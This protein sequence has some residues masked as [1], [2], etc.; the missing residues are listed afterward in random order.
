MAKWLRDNRLSILIFLIL[1]AGFLVRIFFVDKVVVGDLMSYGEWGQRLIQ[2]G[3]KNL[4]FGEGWYYSVPNYPPVAVWTFAGM[5]WLNEH[6]YVL[7]Q[8]HNV[9]RFP[10]SAFIVYF[11]KWGY[12]LLL[13]LPSIIAD[14]GLSL[15]IYKLIFSLTKST[16]KSIA[17]MVLFLFNPI[18]IFISGAWGQTDSIVA[19]LATISFLFLLKKNFIFSIPFLFLSLYFKLSWAVFGPFYLFFLYL[20]K[21][22]IRELLL[23]TA[24]AFSLFIVTTLPFAQG[25]VFTYGWKLFR[26]RYPL[27][28]GIDGKASISAFNFQTIFFRLDIDYSHEKLIGISSGT[29]GLIFYGAVNLIAMINLKKQKNKLLGM[30][31]GLFVIGMGSFLFMATM[32]ERYFFPAFAPMIILMFSRPKI[33]L[34][35]ILINIILA[36]NILYSFYRRGSDELARP[37]TNWNFLLIRILSVV[38]VINFTFITSNLVETHRSG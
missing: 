10:P 8:L 23:G 31:T 20:Q 13:K 34:W 29:W 2:S 16:G 5:F 30:L 12:I 17:G 32:L 22:K 25:N 28:I 36:A 18:I 6:R 9:I 24:I 7:A 21:P 19:I 35:G 1:L 4:Y 11:Y 26:E 37:F 33:L 38:Q 27:P 3:P 15:I 14:L